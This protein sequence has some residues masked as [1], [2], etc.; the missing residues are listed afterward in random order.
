MF[1][2][3]ASGEDLQALTQWVLQTIGVDE[4][5]A[6]A[7]DPKLRFRSQPVRPDKPEQEDDPLN[8]FLLGDLALGPNAPVR[9]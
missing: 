9:V 3:P 8:S 2:D 1:G 7:A 6:D 4:F 5:F